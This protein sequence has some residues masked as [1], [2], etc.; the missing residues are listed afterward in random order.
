M[1]IVLSG[2]NMK[3]MLFY[4]YHFPPIN[5]PSSKRAFDFIVYFADNGWEIDI[6]TLQH[7]CN[8][9]DKSTDVNVPAM[10]SIKRIPTVF[11]YRLGKKSIKPP[12]ENSKAYEADDENSI[13]KIG[14]WLFNRVLDPYFFIPDTFIITLPYFVRDIIKNQN[15]KYDLIFSLGPP[16]TIH[17][18][19]L[20]NKL[21]T[22]KPWVAYWDDPIT[23]G[24]FCESSSLIKNYINRKIESTLVSHSDKI[25]VTTEETK[26]GFINLYQQVL[27]KKIMVLPYYFNKEKFRKISQQSPDKFRIVYTG[28]LSSNTR[29]AHILIEALR[30]IG[31]ENI[32]LCIIGKYHPENEFQKYIDKN[33]ISHIVKYLGSNCNTEEIISYQKGATVLL[34][35][36]WKC[37]YQIPMKL[38]EYI[39]AQRPILSI[40]YDKKDAASKIVKRLKR[41]ICVKND[42]NEIKDALAMLYDLWIIR[43]LDDTFDLSENDEFSF[44]NQRKLLDAS[45]HELLC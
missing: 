40:Q 32:E 16:L 38:Y 13:R 44:E 26:E 10:C 15:K 33:N 14:R 7:K 36:G 6:I 11:F 37:G 30:A 1:R 17:I 35:F 34:L 8:Y 19:G 12:D 18:A 39:G 4:T 9:F 28:T 43:H 45:I 20:I 3:R 29:S 21:I 2:N 25:F 5:S 22:K 23:F 31:K 24:P 27:S 41:G 42:I